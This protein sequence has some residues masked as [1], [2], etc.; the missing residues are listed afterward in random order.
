VKDFNAIML[1]A[2][3][4]PFWLDGFGIIASL[5]RRAWAYC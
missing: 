5:V 4:L 3:A 1:A 2:V